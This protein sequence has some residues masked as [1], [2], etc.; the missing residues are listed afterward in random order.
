[1]SDF[2]ML[3]KARLA[4][5]TGTLRKQADLTF[6][7]CYPSPYF[8]GMS[9]LGFQTIYRRLHELDGV[10]AERAFL[11]D[12]A[13]AA[14]RDGDELLT[15]E[16]G[17]PL[18]DFPVVA[19]SLAYELELAGLVDCL[20]L[21]G[22]PALASARAAR[23][24]RF[25]LVVIGGPLTFSNP[26]PAGPFADVMIMG[27]ADELIAT[28]ADA[29]RD[30]G[31]RAALLSYLA[32]L[33]GFYVPSLHGER[34][35]AIASAPNHM[36]PAYSQIRTAETEL[37]NMFLI[38]PE[39]GCHRGCT[40]CVMRRSTN[41]GM[42]LV[43]P[44]RVLGLV[45]DDARRVGLVGAAVTDHPGLPEILR[46]LVDTGREVGISSLRADRLTDEIVGL[47]KRGGYRTLT[48][49]SDGASERMRTM[50]DR[51]TK[52]RHL[53]RAAELCRAHDLRQLKLYMMLG[54]PTE[55][56]DD[57]DEMGRF[58]LELAA[59][60]PR[61]VLGIAPFVAKKNTPLDGAPFEGVAAIDAKLAQLRAR[62]RGRVTL[63]ATSPKWAF[64]EY[65]LAQ[66]G[67]AAGLAAA[68]AGRAGARYADWKAALA[69]VPEPAVVV[70]PAPPP[71]RPRSLVALER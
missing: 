66:G 14:R 43:E 34:L 1:M 36:L 2:R 31:D 10:S 27:E 20:D 49:A 22:I 58:A 52:E 67:F 54:L 42:R 71:P 33:P 11:P 48:T 28:L 30:M 38:E 8:V 65:R 60:V 12:D 41:G 51:K 57:I 59:I 50:I 53:L 39:R 47:L 23:V 68:K 70:Q 13:R 17:R 15:Y 19:F 32:T 64:I 16:S 26:L 21:A 6:A 9:S 24:D 61:L 7:L 40:Y 63:R 55:T 56:S 25:P 18:C 69:E 4:A 62:V 29:I 35:P 5:E 3:R 45:P 44:S 46:G 37:S